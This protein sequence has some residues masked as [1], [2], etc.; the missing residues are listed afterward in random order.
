MK[1]IRSVTL[2]P[3]SLM[4]Q[5]RYSLQRLAD[6]TTLDRERLKLL[7]KLC[8]T[9]SRH[10][11]IP[12]SMQIPDCSEGSVEVESGGFANVSRST[13]E[14]RWVAVKVV[15]VYVTSDLDVI[16][17]VSLLSAKSHLY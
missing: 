1:W 15:R 13:Y 6:H 11:V 8:K 10:R 14:G 3:I 7:N 5:G 12:K 16:L 17:S 4:S 2:P 9:C